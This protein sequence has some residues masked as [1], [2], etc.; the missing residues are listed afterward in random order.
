MSEIEVEVLPAG[1]WELDKAH[2][3]IGF[4]IEYLAGTF[5]GTFADFDAYLEH[6]VLTGSA[7]VASVQVKDK[8]LAAHLQ[9]PDFFDAGLNPEISFASVGTTR[10]GDSVTIDG[11]ISIK[12]HTEPVQV[13]VGHH[14][15]GKRNALSLDRRLQDRRGIIDLHTAGNGDT[16]R[17]GRS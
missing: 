8:Y 5:R 14:A 15:A 11:A 10:D 16:R 1:L 6:G 13:V 2:S 3:S 17:A 4:A 7:R 9:G 12:G